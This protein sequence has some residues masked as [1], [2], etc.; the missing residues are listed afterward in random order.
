MGGEKEDENFSYVKMS[1]TSYVS[2]SPT[3]CLVSYAERKKKEEEMFE[4]KK[5]VL[6]E[7]IKN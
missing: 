1:F 4:G 6:C 3:L 5:L 2:F 7:Q